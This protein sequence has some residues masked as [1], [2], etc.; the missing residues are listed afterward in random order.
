[1]NDLNENTH[2]RGSAIPVV[3][4]LMIGTSIILGSVLRFAV[5][6]TRL[7]RNNEMWMEAKFTAE[8]I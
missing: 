7:N 3:V 4:I 1:M 8:A 5:S 2:K 6:E